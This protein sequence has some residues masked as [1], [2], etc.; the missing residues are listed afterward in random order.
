VTIDIE[1]GGTRRAI[2]VHR[3]NDRWV[4]T[5]EGRRVVAD[6]ADAGGRWSVIVGQESYE[7]SFEPG[8][9]GE[10]VVHVNGHA[11][12]L[13]IIDPRTAFSSRGRDRGVDDGGPAAIVAPMPGRVVKVLVKQGD[14]VAARQPLVVVEAMKMENELRAPRAGTVIEVRVSEGMSVDPHMVLMMLE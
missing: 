7:V 5:V 2:D 4:V 6:V 12:P 3:E 10:H 13:S 9:S 1:V 14:L 11:V 8:G